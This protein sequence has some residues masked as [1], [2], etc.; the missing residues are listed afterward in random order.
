MEKKAKHKFNEL[1]AKTFTNT[2]AKECTNI[3]LRL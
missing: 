3:Y 1:K 2:N